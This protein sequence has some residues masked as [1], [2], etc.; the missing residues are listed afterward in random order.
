MISLRYRNLE[1]CCSSHSV[2]ENITFPVNLML[3][4]MSCESVAVAYE[5]D[6]CELQRYALH[7]ST[8]HLE[9]NCSDF[10]QMTFLI[11]TMTKKSF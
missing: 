5:K 7:Y 1:R 3:K 4:C 11:K 2:S 9:N 6:T 8:A 10:G